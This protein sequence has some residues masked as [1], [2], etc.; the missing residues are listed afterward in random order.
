MA[1]SDVNVLLSSGPQ[2]WLGPIGGRPNG[3]PGLYL[4][5]PAPKLGG[6][7]APNGSP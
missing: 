7:P 3:W 2:P 1:P 6:N 4:A 5:R